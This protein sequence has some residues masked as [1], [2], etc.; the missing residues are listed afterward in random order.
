MTQ[1]T[2]DTMSKEF[3]KFWSELS[4]KYRRKNGL[5]PSPEELDKELKNFSPEPLSEYE[6]ESIVQKVTSNEPTRISG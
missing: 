2:G 5:T 3:D 4:R 1:N 6:I